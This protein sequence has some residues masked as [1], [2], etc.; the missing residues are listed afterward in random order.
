MSPTAEFSRIAAAVD[1]VIPSP[2]ADDGAGLSPPLIG[3]RLA[4]PLMSTGPAVCDRC[5]PDGEDGSGD[6]NGEAAMPQPWE[7]KLLTILKTEPCLTIR[8]RTWSAHQVV[9]TAR[10]VYPGNRYRLE[11]RN[12]RIFE[13]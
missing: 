7:C 6:A 1:A 5:D 3:V 2:S 10:L 4:L 12:G 13:E 11:A 9:S 8:R